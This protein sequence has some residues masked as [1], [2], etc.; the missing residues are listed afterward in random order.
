VPTV[1]EIVMRKPGVFTVGPSGTVYDALHTMALRDIGALV[2]VND[3]EAIVGVFSERDYARKV[4]LQGKSSRDLAVADIMSSPVVC[5]APAWSV[6]DCMAVMT[7]HRVRH[8]P[9]V[10]EG[11]LVGI[12]SIGDVVSAVVTEQASTILHL[13]RYISAGG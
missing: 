11:R 12:V 8:L 9:V 13:E 7:D 6:Y 10:D 3:Q 4:I 5:A 2:V 1:R